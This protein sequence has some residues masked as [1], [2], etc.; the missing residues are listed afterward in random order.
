LVYCF[1]FHL[2]VLRFF[3]LLDDIFEL[4]FNFWSSSCASCGLAFKIQILCLCVV[5]VLIKGEIEK[6]SGQYLGLICDE[7]LT[8]L[9]LNLNPGNLGTPTLLSISCGEM[10]LLVS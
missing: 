1:S 6:P 8:C 7:E 10:C 3:L 4:F 9:G 2:L 5:N